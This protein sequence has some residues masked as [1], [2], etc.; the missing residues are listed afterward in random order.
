MAVDADAD[1]ALVRLYGSSSNLDSSIIW[2][3]T[4]ELQGVPEVVAER[5][6]CTEIG[7]TA[8]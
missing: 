4:D 1:K 7:A 3:T 8:W 5:E 6:R 2:K